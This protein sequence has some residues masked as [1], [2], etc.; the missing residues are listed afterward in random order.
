MEG[1]KKESP[2]G[3]QEVVR[4]AKR[5]VVQRKRKACNPSPRSG[6]EFRELREEEKDLNSFV[7]GRSV[8]RERGRLLEKL[9]LKGRLMFHG[10]RHGSVE[11]SK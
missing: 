3:T 9:S 5:A 11:M 4:N 6:Q 2:E 7:G 10:S 1:K 8:E